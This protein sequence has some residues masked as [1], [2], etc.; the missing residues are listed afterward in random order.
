MLRIPWWVS[1]CILGGQEPHSELA[2][3]L[4]QGGEA[5]LDHADGLRR[6]PQ[7]E[8]TARGT[9]THAGQHEVY[10]LPTGALVAPPQLALPFDLAQWG[11]GSTVGRT[12]PLRPLLAGAGLADAE[13]QMVAE[14]QCGNGA[15]PVGSRRA[16]RLARHELGQ[17][18]AFLKGQG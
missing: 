5:P 11:H 15:T 8:Y 13:P 12:L 4:H 7:Q 1:S 10:R 9:Y 6:E 16:P 2:R 18:C 14:R 3:R 17:E